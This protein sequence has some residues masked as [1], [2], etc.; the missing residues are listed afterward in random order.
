MKKPPFIPTQY[1]AL[2][3]ISKAWADADHRKV[4]KLA[5]QLHEIVG[6]LDYARKLTHDGSRAEAVQSSINRRDAIDPTTADTVNTPTFAI[7]HGGL[8]WKWNCG[9]HLWDQTKNRSSGIV[10][11]HMSFRRKPLC[12]QKDKSFVHL[13]RPYG[14]WRRYVIS[15][16]SHILFGNVEVLATDGIKAMVRCD[17]GT[18]QPVMF[19]NLTEI[20]TPLPRKHKVHSVKGTKKK[21]EVAITKERILSLL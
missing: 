6:K 17:D 12:H 9:W 20:P 16:M 18:T 1:P 8:M 3:I 19:A 10:L 14:P 15:R 7:T 13:P 4:Y 21:V 2:E 11:G 5:C